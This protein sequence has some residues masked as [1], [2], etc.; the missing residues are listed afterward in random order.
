MKYPTCYR[1]FIDLCFT[2]KLWKN[3]KKLKIMNVRPFDVTLRDGLQTLSNEEQ[4]YFTT[5]EKIKLYNKINREHNPINL[6]IGSNVNYKL[7]PIFKDTKELYKNVE[8]NKMI[9]EKEVNNYILVP[10]HN[11]LIDV[12]LYGATNFSF[13]TSVSNSFQLKNTNMNLERNFENLNLMM[14]I[15][16]KFNARN[17]DIFTEKPKYKVKLYI[18]CIT[19]CPIEGKL[20]LQFIVNKILLLEKLNFN[21]ICLSDTCGTMTKDEFIFIMDKLIEN[22]VNIRKISLHLHIHP[23]REDEI[24]EIVHIALDYGIIE[25]DVSYLKYGG[26]VMTLDKNKT[27]PNMNYDQFYKFITNYMAKTQK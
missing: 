5:L 17:L 8:L 19:E 27:Y 21:T 6:E 16:D 3:E 7:F 12:L 14:N 10:S 18:S 22:G 15:L 9:Y 20:P 11:K 24:E 13:I 25:F 1:S 26:C 4:Q 23:S 2:N